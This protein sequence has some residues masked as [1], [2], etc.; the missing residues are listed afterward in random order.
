MVHSDN[1]PYDYLVGACDN[2]S[3]VVSYVVVMGQG[4]ASNPLLG[5]RIHDINVESEIIRSIPQ[6]PDP[7]ESDGTSGGL[8]DAVDE[9][10]RN[11]VDNTSSD[12]A[13]MIESWWEL[14]AFWPTFFIAMFE[15]NAQARY[16][17][18]IETDLLGN[19]EI[20]RMDVSCIA[21]EGYPDEE[22][23][24]FTGQAIDDFTI[25]VLY[26]AGFAATTTIYYL[27]QIMKSNT[28]NP[29]VFMPSLMAW[30]ATFLGYI[31]LVDYFYVNGHDLA[32]ECGLAML[33]MLV[34]LL[35]DSGML[36]AV[37]S[38]FAFFGLILPG[39]LS[40]VLMIGGIV[41]IFDILRNLNVVLTL[42]VTI[43]IVI[44]IWYLIK[45]FTIWFIESWD[46]W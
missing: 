3:R 23:G 12:I 33:S 19:T 29:A 16:D 40:V 15:Q 13:N 39:I 6:I 45:Y 26:I 42:S 17:V 35:I 5:M 2:A 30:W 27:L 7:V 34:I 22:I 41:E 43:A 24:E 46:P 1:A 32:I 36:A 25:G 14:V 38:G 44:C 8:S 11:D 10:T 20:E 21:A 37:K 9:T 18:Y 4:Y 28:L 31:A